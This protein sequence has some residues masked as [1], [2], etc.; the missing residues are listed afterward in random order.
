MQF[1]P[2]ACVLLAR[3]LGF[4]TRPFKVSS[5]ETLIS[6]PQGKAV[7]AGLIA[8]FL[9]PRRLPRP[10][11]AHSRHPLNG[12]KKQASCPLRHS[13]A[14][15]WPRR[16]RGKWPGLANLG[17][18]SMVPTHFCYK[19]RPVRSAQEAAGEKK[20]SLIFPCSLS[21]HRYVTVACF[22]PTSALTELDVPTRSDSRW[23]VSVTERA[24][25]STASRF[26]Y[27]EYYSNAPLKTFCNSARAFPRVILH[28]FRVTCTS[29]KSVCDAG[30]SCRECVLM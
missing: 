2:G 20:A 26:T 18:T 8:V 13:C 27:R 5:Y 4:N 24:R 19:T 6:A 3:L 22:K 12:S 14:G 15:A 21:G 29:R 17:T 23:H 10:N 25:F 11:R 7:S 1:L 28:H 30:S 9:V 16:P